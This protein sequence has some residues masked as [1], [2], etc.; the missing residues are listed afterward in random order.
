MTPMMPMAPTITSPLGLTMPPATTAAG[1]IASLQDRVAGILE[2]LLRKNV[3]PPAPVRPP[4][5]SPQIAGP[6]AEYLRLQAEALALAVEAL[7]LRVKPAPA[8]A[9]PPGQS[10]KQ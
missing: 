5:L 1:L 4:D 3:V 2:A 8:G 10:P 6:D 9:K 7:N